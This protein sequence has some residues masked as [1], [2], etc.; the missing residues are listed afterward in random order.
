V[1]KKRLPEEWKIKLRD[2]L[3]HRP[4]PKPAV[5]LKDKGNKAFTDGD[6]P[7]A[8]LLYSEALALTPDDAILCSNRSIA[9]L[10]AG[11]AAGALAD[12]DRCIEIDPK[13]VKG[14]ARR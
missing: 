2:R 1:A 10:K 13:M 4:E 12:A 3:F 11:D 9:R 7:L 14:Q 8:I 6:L 5:V